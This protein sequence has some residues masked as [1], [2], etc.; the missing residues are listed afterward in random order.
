MQ[1]YH[2][3]SWIIVLYLA[4]LPLQ[5][6]SAKQFTAQEVLS[7]PPLQADYRISYG[8]DSLNFGDLRLPEGEGPHPVAVLIHGGCWLSFATLQYFDRFAVALTE[9][10]FVTWNIEYRRVDSVG[11]GWPNTFLD[12]ADGLD[13]LRELAGEYDLDLNRI[14]IIGHSSGG[15]LATWAA[16]R[17][18]IPKSSP[19]YSSNPLGVAGVVNIAGPLDLALFRLFDNRV[20]GGDVIDRLVGGTPEEVPTHY[21]AAS[22]VCMLPLGIPQR[23]LT[24][25]DDK[26]VPPQYGEE[27]A[28]RAREAGDDV[29]M[30]V[31]PEAGHF[32]LV[33]PWSEVWSVV[34]K[35]VLMMVREAK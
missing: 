12:V 32:E 19:L 17:H 9:M 3:C 16:A 33:A 31:I 4:A 26:A 8:M 6:L 2:L 10:R 23:L 30:H 28:V 24:G 11:G 25:T 13:H 34:P 27:Y 22:P 29:Q 1:Q 20:C 14:V 21:A 35:V 18:R 5:R 15:H 7:L